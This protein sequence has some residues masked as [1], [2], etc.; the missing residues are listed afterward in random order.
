M[1]GIS[2][3]NYFI[4]NIEKIIL[5]AVSNAKKQILEVLFN[6]PSSI[7]AGIIFK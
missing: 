2:V 5:I 4:Q 7:P 6:D 3:S 1:L